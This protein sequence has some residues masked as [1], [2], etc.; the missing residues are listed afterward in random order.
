[1]ALPRGLKI[2]ILIINELEFINWQ[3]QPI[4]V[5]KCGTWIKGDSGRSD[6]ASEALSTLCPHAVETVML[7]IVDR[8]FNRRMLAAHPD[9]P[10][11]RHCGNHG[12]SL[13]HVDRETALLDSRRNGTP[14]FTGHPAL[15][16][17]IRRVCSSKSENTFSCW[18]IFSHLSRRRA[19]CSMQ[20]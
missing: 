19:A 17:D 16:F 11:C 9:G 1:M 8:R 3:N 7:K 4:I 6:R 13:L 5:K 15:P 20:R 10:G 14:S 18:G 2:N 12:Q